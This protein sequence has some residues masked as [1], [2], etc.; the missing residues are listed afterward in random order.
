MANNQFL[1][2]KLLLRTLINKLINYQLINKSINDS[3]SSGLTARMSQLGM[4]DG[5]QGHSNYQQKLPIYQ[6]GGEYST[7]FYCV[8][9]HFFILFLSSTP[10][11][12]WIV[13]RDSSFLVGDTSVKFFCPDSSP[14]VR[15]L[16]MYLW[17]IK[18]RY[19]SHPSSSFGEILYLPDYFEWQVI[20][21]LSIRLS[22]KLSPP[23]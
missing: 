22:D 9:T 18:T 12:R 3:V 21:F 4:N 16:G 15:K 8:L 7:L 2:S 19:A 5:Y 17:K 14:C 20:F 1:T 23:N 10:S 11:A 6:V 13:P